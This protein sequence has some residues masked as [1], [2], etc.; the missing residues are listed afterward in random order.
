MASKHG[1]LLVSLA[2]LLLYSCHY[3]SASGRLLN[4]MKPTSIEFGIDPP[5]LLKPAFPL[6]EDQETQTPPGSILPALPM[7]LQQPIMTPPPPAPFP[8]G[9]DEAGWIPAFP[10]PHLPS[11]PAL[12]SFPLAPQFVDSGF[13]S[14]GI[15][16]EGSRGK[17]LIMLEE[18]GEK[19]REGG[20][21]ENEGNGIPGIGMFGNGGKFFISPKPILAL[22]LSILVGFSFSSLSRRASI[23]GA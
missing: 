21:N 9:Q 7:P 17:K 18:I 14:P 1:L 16:D 3:C 6:P 23:F 22:I 5:Y 20:G 10:F 12:P 8:P 11:V 13:T 19:G 4:P 2:F 15:G